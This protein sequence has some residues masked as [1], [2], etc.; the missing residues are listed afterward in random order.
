MP[1]KPIKIQIR[2]YNL[3]A[4]SEAI[5]KAGKEGYVISDTNE[6]YPR[7]FIGEFFTEMI[8]K[9]D[10]EDVQSVQEVKEQRPAGRPRKQS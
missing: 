9:E 6:G 5:A 8:L 3:V 1:S 4:Y 2:E 10:E 7:Q